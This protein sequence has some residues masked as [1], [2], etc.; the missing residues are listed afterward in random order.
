MARGDGIGKGGVV[1]KI[2]IQND[3]SRSDIQA[4]QYVISVIRPGRISD[5]GKAYPFANTFLDG[6][7]VYATR[8]Y[9]SDKFV[10]QD[11]IAVPT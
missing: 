5:D 2:I 3:S 1:S 9:K 11:C 4:L 8:N 6:V 7:V 10:V